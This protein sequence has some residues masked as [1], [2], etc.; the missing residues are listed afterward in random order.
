[1]KFFFDNRPRF[2]MN[3]L[4]LVISILQSILLLQMY[5]FESDL[6][7]FEDIRMFFQTGMPNPSACGVLFTI[8]VFVSVLYWLKIV[9]SPKLSTIVAVVFVYFGTMITIGYPDFGFNWP[10]SVHLMEAYIGYGY[11]YY[12][13]EN[14]IKATFRPSTKVITI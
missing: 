11:S 14:F 13:M 3:L 10:T 1:M 7:Y 8:W 12:R 4:I 5:I 2:T 6:S 9:K